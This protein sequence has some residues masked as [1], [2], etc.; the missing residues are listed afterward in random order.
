VSSY[1]KKRLGKKDKKKVCCDKILVHLTKF[2]PLG[3]MH[4]V[5][6]SRCRKMTTHCVMWDAP[7]YKNNKRQQPTYNSLHAHMKDAP[8]HG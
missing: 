8:N 3:F 2:K 5:V 6:I 7:N 4:W 1:G